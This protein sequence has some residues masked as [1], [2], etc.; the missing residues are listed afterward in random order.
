[1]N[2]LF[3]DKWR[4]VPA[5]APYPACRL[6]RVEY[7]IRLAPVSLRDERVIERSWRKVREFIKAEGVTNTWR[8]IRSKREQGRLNGDFHVV[9]AVGAEISEGGDTPSS[10]S[11][12]LCLGTRHPRAA[13]VM[14]FRR[15]LTARL[16]V[17]PTAEACLRVVE[18]LTGAPDAS[19][20]L[21]NDIAGYN[22]YSDAPP[23]VAAQQFMATAASRLNGEAAESQS[24]DEQSQLATTRV[25]APTSRIVYPSA[26]IETKG[27][28]RSETTQRDSPRVVVV[29]AGDYTRT[30]IAPELSRAGMTLH[31]IV[32]LEP[33][34]AE[35]MREK[36]GF[37][38]AM[39][40]WR[41][42]IS[43][44]DADAVIVASY[45]DS[46]A[47]IAAEALRQGKRAFVEKPPVVTREDLDLLLEAASLPG[48]FL[49]VGYNRRYAP[50]TRRAKELMAGVAGATTMVCVVKEVGIPDGHWYRWTKEG[51]RITGNLCHWIDLCTHLAGADR[52]A[53]E[54]N[55]TAPA[56][57]R[58]PDEERGL[59]ILFDDDSTATIIAASR[60]DATLGVQEFIEVRREDMTIRIDDFRRLT[61][62]RNG[63]TLERLS[64]QRDKGHAAM[65]REAMRRIKNNEAARYTLA[66]LRRSAL[67][68]ITATEMAQSDVRRLRIDV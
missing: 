54:I 17:K 47:L 49:E 28:P 31:T 14:L 19:D 22:F 5:Y 8:K 41:E 33:Y 29:A 34:R 65:Y 35:Y 61:A 1:M 37:G 11:L 20:T 51:T 48:A 6:V 63:R 13:E 26:R 3:L 66:E 67:L 12:L 27:K 56:D 2:Y 9:L 59:N 53:V 40:D 30:T 21:W 42:A 32:D 39:T 50:F 7:A 10:A 43:Q 44:P 62:T 46:H 45:H 18:E 57:R 58:H 25:D 15:E 68:T 38:R 55:L 64:G 52:R 36:C 16:A 23:P 4:D 24:R 60:G